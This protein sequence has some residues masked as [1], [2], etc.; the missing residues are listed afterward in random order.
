M[1][2]YCID[3]T[4]PDTYT[5]PV[6]YGTYV[7]MWLENGMAPAFDM[8]EPPEF[9]AEHT[10]YFNM[11]EAETRSWLDHMRFYEQDLCRGG[12]GL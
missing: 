10:Y 3:A 1:P 9:I 4:E 2:F 5:P 11:P 6:E 12:P 7:V 8:A